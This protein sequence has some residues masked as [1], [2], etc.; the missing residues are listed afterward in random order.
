MLSTTD[1]LRLLPKAEL[2]CHFV[3]TMRM[4]TLVELAA[5][6]DVPLKTDDLT[7]LLDYTGLPD[8]LD[9]F[10]AAHRVLTTGDEIARVAYEGVEDAVR[11]GNLRYRE[12][13]VN[14]DNFAPYGIDYATLVDAMVDG[15]TQAESDF[16]VGF[17][18]VA[19]INRALPASAA[20]AMVETVLAHPRDAV[21]GIGQD[22]LTP[23]FTEDPARFAEAYALAERHGLRRTAHVGETMT[24]APHDVV[25]AIAALR[26]DRV[27]HG[28]R[29]VDDP[30]ALARAQDSGIPFTCTP[31]S[32]VELSG[33][34]FGPDH[35]IARMIAAGLHVSLA[36]D[37]A[38]FFKTDIAREYT[39]AL[40]QM[41]IGT[42][43]AARIARA[44]FEAAWCDDDQRARLLA[45]ADG[46]IAAL[47]GALGEEATR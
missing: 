14:P 9:V 35:R 24:A 45:D 16:G 26:L 34:R 41:G 12:Y 36:T 38:V 1:Y 18:I 29:V 7:A 47:T 46:A 42:T 32:T 3:S 6:H 22:D 31:H 17:R 5:A 19:A 27:D 10:N 23:E 2:H 4:S 33:W 28:Y 43:D 13:F 37:D 11:C 40:P 44:G 8:F 30:D 20:V 39:V 25:D 21:V 15:F